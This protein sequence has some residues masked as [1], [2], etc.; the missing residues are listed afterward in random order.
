[1][2]RWSSRATVELVLRAREQQPEAWEELFERCSLEMVRFCRRFMGPYD[3]LRR[4][5]QSQDIV[6]EAF[7]TAIRKIDSLRSDASFYAWVRTIIRHKIAVKRRNELR[8]VPVTPSREPAEDTRHE[9]E[10][11]TCEESLN[12]VEAILDLFE[13]YPDAMTAFAMV[14]LE[15]V[16]PETLAEYLGVSKRTAY[17]RLEEATKLLRQRLDS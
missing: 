3:P 4:I 10:L 7:A 15:D 14:H 13:E 17:R 11:S 9:K 5:Y 8:N 1:M 6:Q 16:A 2:A 12:V